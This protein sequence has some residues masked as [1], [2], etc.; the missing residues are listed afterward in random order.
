MQNEGRMKVI[1]FQCERTLK[2]HLLKRKKVAGR[3]RKTTFI[4]D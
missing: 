3:F 4:V 2:H 1:E